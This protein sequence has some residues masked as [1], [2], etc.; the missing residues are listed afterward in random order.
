M[1]LAPGTIDL[2]STSDDK[3]LELANRMAVT[4]V[5]ITRQT[6][7]CL[8]QDLNPKG[9]TVDEVAAHWCLAKALASLE[10]DD[11]LPLQSKP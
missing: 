9:F 5:E 10:L 6:G 1:T 8:P 7:G 11:L 3:K 4:I 2:I